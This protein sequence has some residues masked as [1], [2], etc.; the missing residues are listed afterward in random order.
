VEDKDAVALL[1]KR[2]DLG[3]PGEAVPIS[4]IG[5]PLTRGEILP[6]FKARNLNREATVFTAE[7]FTVVIGADV[8]CPSGCSPV[9]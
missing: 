3:L 1:L 5:F 8:N 9:G 6:L 7:A 2:I 4:A